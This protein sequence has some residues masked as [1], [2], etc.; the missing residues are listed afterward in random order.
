MTNLPELAVPF[1]WSANVV[2][3]VR[4]DDGSR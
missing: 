1:E 2:V 3:T 4:I